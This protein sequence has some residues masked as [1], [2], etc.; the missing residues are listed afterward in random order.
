[1]F[2]SNNIICG[3]KKSIFNKIQERSEL[4]LNWHVLII[5]EMISLK[6][7]KIANKFLLV[8]DKFM[9]KLHLRQ[10]GFT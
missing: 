5:F 4:Q 10:S 2:L 6:W 7:I 1:M 8:G 9:V 3:K